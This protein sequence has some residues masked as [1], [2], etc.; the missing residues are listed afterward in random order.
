[1]FNGLYASIRN[2]WYWILT[3]SK[4]IS[5]SHQIQFLNRKTICIIC[6][7][8]GEILFPSPS[9]YSTSEACRWFA[10][11]KTQAVLHS[12]AAARCLRSQAPCGRHR[13]S[14]RA[15]VF[16]GRS[17]G[18]DGRLWRLA[19]LPRQIAPLGRSLRGL[20]GGRR[21][22]FCRVVPSVSQPLLPLSL[23]T[24]VGGGAESCC[25]AE[26]KEGCPLPSPL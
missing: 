10:K 5:H 22:F 2:I 14:P 7:H 9:W 18:L 21:V 26:V 25:F 24:G 15:L 4:L 1:M 3:Q 11:A 19:S 23:R 20:G 8:P 16:V 17:L 12:T 6:G 13:A